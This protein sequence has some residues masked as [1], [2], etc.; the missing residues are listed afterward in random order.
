VIVMGL[1]LLVRCGRSGGKSVRFETHASYS[2]DGKDAE[3]KFLIALCKIVIFFFYVDS[4]L[5]LS[6]AS[7][8]LNGLFEEIDT[9]ST[10]SSC[11]L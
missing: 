8:S 2:R 1:I 6:S 5:I 11:G 7:H 10:P 4:I 9:F 3:V